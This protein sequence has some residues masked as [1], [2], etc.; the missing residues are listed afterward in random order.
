M[1]VVDPR[2]ENEASS[3]TAMSDTSMLFEFELEDT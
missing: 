3:V 2:V 1:S